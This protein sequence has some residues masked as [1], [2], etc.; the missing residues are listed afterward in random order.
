MKTKINFKIAFFLVLILI[1]FYSCEREGKVEQPLPFGP[2]SLT[3]LL[4]VSLSP[5]VLAAGT[6]RGS[7]TMTATLR[8]Y[9]SSSQTYNAEAGETIIFEICNAAQTPINTGYFEGSGSVLETVTDANGTVT[10][11]Y[12]GPLATEIA[13]STTV[14]IWATVARE[15][16]ES[17]YQY[18]PIGIIQSAAG[19]GINI[20]ANPT[21]LST[22]AVRET[23]TIT[24][25]LMT[26]VG[27]IPLANWGI[28]LDIVDDEGE[29]LYAGY[30]DS[31]AQVVTKFTDANGTITAT[32]NTPLSL[33]LPDVGPG[34]CL[35]VYIRATTWL[36]EIPIDAMTSIYIC[37]P[38]EN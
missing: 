15:G 19:I 5:N 32:Y 6:T 35:T 31:N 36:G 17:I 2:S 28:R 37:Q 9:D 13:T 29:K 33:E 26:A 10:A 30:F 24:A 1:L 27:G 23:S 21:T 34:G 20:Y 3:V 8:K 16:K 11:T 18:A 4:N 14:Y 25:T 38:E 7:S 22:S 12:Y